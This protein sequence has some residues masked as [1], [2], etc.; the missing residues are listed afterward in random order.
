MQ[1]V[2]CAWAWAL[3]IHV[4]GW[5]M[6]IHPGHIILEKRKPAL[7]DSFIQVHFVSR[8]I[9]SQG[10]GLQCELYVEGWT[11]FK[12]VRNQLLLN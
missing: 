7:L 9:S 11:L 10:I 5:Y 12:S 1:N 6:Q 4:L 8:P 3:A 2:S